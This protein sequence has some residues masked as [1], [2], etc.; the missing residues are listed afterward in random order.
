MVCGK[1]R[2]KKGKVAR[3][4]QRDRQIIVEGLNVIIRHRRPRREREKGQRVE[5]SAPLDVSNVKFLCPKCGKATRVGY[6]LDSEG[7]KKRCCKKCQQ[8][9]E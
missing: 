4:L 7:Q 3:C 8:V 1:D 5:V 6:R 2:G 9:I